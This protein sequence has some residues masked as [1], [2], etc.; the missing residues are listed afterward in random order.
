MTTD[1][2]DSPD[3]T[4][5]GLTAVELRDLLAS[6]GISARE[7]ADHFLSRIE[8][9]NPRLGSFITVTAERALADADAADQAAVRA[10]TGAQAL[11]PL[12]GMPL[13]YKDL[14]DVEGVPTTFGSAAVP[15]ATAREDSPLVARLRT[16]GAISL[17]KTQIPEF[18]LNCY[19]ENLIAPPARHPVDPSLSPGGSSGGS[20]AAVAAGL[21]PVAPG[22]DGGGSVR[23]PA[24]ACGL[25]GLKPGLGTVPA[26][27]ANGR[28]DRFGA[29]RFVV[30]GPLARTAEDAGLLMDSLTGTTG[31][32]AAARRARPASG[33]ALRIG[34]SRTSPF[35]THYPISLAPEA[36][37]AL[38]AGIGLLQAAGHR[39]EEADIRYDNRYADA[40]QAIW[41]AGL[42]EAGLPD[43][44]APALMELT[45]SFR[46]RALARSD[47]DKRDAA[48]VLQ[49]IA[50]DCRAQWGRYDAVLTPA[51]AQ[52]PRPIGWY[53]SHDAD[54]DYELQCRYTPYTSV[55]NVAGTP[56]VTVPTL[57]TDTGLSMG[58]Q[59]IGANGSE[60]DLLALAA[61]LMHAAN[62][63]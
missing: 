14:W 8:E 41:T 47:G 37:A 50:G 27:L 6:G 44:A 23:I 16:D 2:D 62:D 56:A 1:H 13:A 45:R 30:S 28:V 54:F 58:I 52:T 35:E 43:E 59:L 40:F 9:H 61:Q 19:S 60:A 49:K 34:L 3:N 63:M 25:V 17:G 46:A 24:S 53:T 10:R 26:D 22:N 42:A 32:L 7:A 38:Q 29:P 39:V 31:Y 57:R 5:G 36:E 33:R 21:L 11:P 12:H 51:M 20:A 18:G 4:I 48:T 15:H 55:V